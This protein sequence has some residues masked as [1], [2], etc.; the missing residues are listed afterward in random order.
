M[1]NLLIYYFSL[2]FL[3]AIAYLPFG[4]LYKFSD[5]VC[6]VL[7]RIFGYRKRVVY[8]NLQNA[9]PEKSAT[10]IQAIAQE[11]YRHFCDIILETIKTLTL[12]EDQL[13]DRM[14]FDDTAIFEKYQREKRSV[15]I[16]CGHTGN[17]EYGGARFAIEN[18]HDLFVLYH[19][20]HNR[21]FDQ[22]IYRMR[23]RFGYDL[24]PMK[25]ALKGMFEHK[26]K[27]SAT[28]FIADQTPAPQHAHWM[29]FLNQDTPVFLGT[30][31]I[32]RKFNYPVIYMSVRR[33]RRGHYAIMPELLFDQPR[34]TKEFEITEAHT[35]RLEKDIRA[36][37]AVWLWSHR[38]W[39]HRRLV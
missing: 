9:F 13:R 28:A 35:R 20:L 39:K 29:N 3:Y 11:F 4:I 6:F 21:H 32:A 10:E 15:L 27:V 18:L 33:L 16:V 17:W 25:K 30:E 1:I 26:N 31:K 14:N 23:T 24:F 5:F 36:Q 7:F 34:Q 38:R 2:P 22:L 19:P 37:P 12:T 8:Q